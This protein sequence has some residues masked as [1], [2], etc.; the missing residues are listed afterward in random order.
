MATALSGTRAGMTTYCRGTQ[1]ISAFLTNTNS[2]N[3][4]SG[5]IKFIGCNASGVPDGTRF[6]I[7]AN[8]TGTGGFNFAA[9]TNMIWLENIAV[10]NTA[11]SNTGFY[12]N[13]NSSGNVLINCA[14]ANCGSHGFD[15]HN[16][17]S[18]IN[19]LIRCTS[20]SNGGNGFY[21]TYGNIFLYC[22]A[23]NNSGVAGFYLSNTGSGTLL[24]GCLI[25]DNAG[26]GITQFNEGI[27][28]VNSVVDNNTSGGILIG[29]AVNTVTP[30]I[31]SCRITNNSA[32]GIIGG[33]LP[34]LTLCNYFEN[35]VGG[36]LTGNTLNN[37]IDIDGSGNDSNQYDQSNPNQGYTSVT[38]GSENFNLV[39]GSATLFRQGIVIPTT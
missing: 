20:Y 10:E 23:H 25:Y 39:S 8:N 3:T 14:A 4:T 7:N 17:G 31:N 37:L 21:T 34:F 26:Y 18:P 27:V 9:T 35:N 29:T 19:T 11:V 32:Q 1:V 36:D 16:A 2:G 33:N 38:P 28:L 5:F 15:L 24:L 12:F 22:S 6:T 13:T 30:I